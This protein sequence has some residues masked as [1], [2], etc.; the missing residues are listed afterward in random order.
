QGQESPRVRASLETVLYAE[1]LQSVRRSGLRR[2]A[3]AAQGG[4]GS[5]LRS[6]GGAGSSDGIPRVGAVYGGALRRSAGRPAPDARGA[7]HLRSDDPRRKCLLAEPAPAQRH[8]A[9]VSGF[10]TRLSVPVPRVLHPT[11][12]GT[13][14]R[15]ALS[16]SM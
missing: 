12:R 9:D 5:A 14:F 15:S 8:S 2:K 4:S 10:R 16:A 13:P 1:R 6:A 3:A 11:G 7:W